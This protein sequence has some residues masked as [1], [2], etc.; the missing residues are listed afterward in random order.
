M[1]ALNYAKR[2][3]SISLLLSDD[4]ASAVQFSQLSEKLVEQGFAVSAFP[5]NRTWKHDVV[6]KLPKY[7]VYIDKSHA[8]QNII[9]R[10]KKIAKNNKSYYIVS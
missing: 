1:L 10:R 7:E 8:T 5:C 4:V 6:E 9:A 3:N 2:R